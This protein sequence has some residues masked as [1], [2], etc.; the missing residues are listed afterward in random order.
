MPLGLH[1]LDNSVS[2]HDQLVVHYSWFVVKH[3]YW[4][5]SLLPLNCKSSLT[6][7]FGIID[8]MLSVQR[9]VYW[10]VPHHTKYCSVPVSYVV[11]KRKLL[12]WT[13]YHQQHVCLH[14]SVDENMTTDIIVIKA[15][16]RVITE[17]SPGIICRSG[18]LDWSSQNGRSLCDWLPKTVKT[19]GKF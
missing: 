13:K 1:S 14:A 15:N 19:T 3:F 16:H 12:I 17:L 2:I 8:Q 9:F 10:Q 4:L 7:L 11:N 18:R 6:Y 5:K